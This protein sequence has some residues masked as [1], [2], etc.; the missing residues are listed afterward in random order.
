MPPLGH[1]WRY[2][3]VLAPIASL[4]FP[5]VRTLV[6]KQMTEQDSLDEIKQLLLTYH[7]MESASVFRVPDR[8]EVWIRF[9]CIDASSIRSIAA[10]SVWANVTI[11]LGDPNTTLCEESAGAPCLPCDLQIPDTE[12]QSP[13]HVE[14]FG[15]YISAN[16]AENGLISKERLETLHSR[17]KTRLGNRKRKPPIA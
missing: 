12:T 2:A 1:R 8:H 15:V 5:S 17:W 6:R 4:L 10:E 7:G 9:R 3:L 11:T 13:T 16:L 14:R